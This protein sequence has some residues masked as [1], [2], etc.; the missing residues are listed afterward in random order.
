MADVSITAANVLKGT[1]NTVENGTAGATIT[2]GQAVYKKGT[3]GLFYHTDVLAASVTANEE[4]KE[5][6][7]IALNSASAN[8][9]LQVQRT[10]DIT[11]GGTV[12]ESTMYYLASSGV[13]A[14]GGICPLADLVSTDWYVIVGIATS[15]TVIHMLPYDSNTQEP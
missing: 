11:I 5:L 12:V 4:I 14:A 3:D 7:G 10:G 15:A 13:G 1:T 9:T 8:Q 2:A 6:Y